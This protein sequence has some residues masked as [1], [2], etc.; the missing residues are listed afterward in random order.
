MSVSPTV[1]ARSVDRDRRLDRLEQVRSRYAYRSREENELHP[2]AQTKYYPWWQERYDS[3]W[4]LPFLPGYG[5]SFARWA[6][7]RVRFALQRAA[8]RFDKMR[9]YR[10]MLPRDS[11]PLAEHSESA[12]SM[13]PGGTPIGE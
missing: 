9:A 2:I 13:N 5:V 10:Q 12:Y 8:F 4:M 11:R 6:G 3:S 7:H 1:P